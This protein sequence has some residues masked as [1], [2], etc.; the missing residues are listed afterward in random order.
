MALRFSM[1]LGWTSPVSTTPPAVQTRDATDR[2]LSVRPR[3]FELEFVRFSSGLRIREPLELDFESRSL[4]NLDHVVVSAT[5][6]MFLVFREDLALATG[7][8]E[9]VLPVLLGNT[10][11]GILLVTV[12]NYF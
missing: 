1:S 11:G 12:V 2:R 6:A 5:E 9:F 8:F 7:V 10:I 4:G 3:E